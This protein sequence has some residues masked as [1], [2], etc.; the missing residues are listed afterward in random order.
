[1]L[2]EAALWSAVL[3][4]PTVLEGVWPVTGVVAE[5]CPGAGLAAPAVWSEA[6]LGV[7]PA[8]CPVAP[9]L[10]LLVEPVASAEEACCFVQVS[11]ILLTEVTWK[12]PSLACEP[13]TCTFCPS[14]GLIEE[15]SPVM[16][17]VWPLSDVS[18]QFPP[19]CLRHPVREFWAPEDVVLDVLGVVPCEVLGGG[20]VCCVLLGLV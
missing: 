10:A 19:D 6:L 11:E 7:V 16:F 15:E 18:T 14:N 2:V 12:E 20:L 1:V 8:A 9:A 17:T 13:C 4:L 5:L 3:P